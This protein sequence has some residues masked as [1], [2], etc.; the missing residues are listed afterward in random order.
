MIGRVDP[1]SPRE[2]SSDPLELRGYV[3]QLV[4]EPLLFL[5]VSY[6]DELTLHIG[7]PRQ[8]RSRRMAHLTKGSYVIG[9][10]ASLWFL[11]TQSPPTVVIGT[12]NLAASASRHLKPL[13]PEELESSDLMKPGTRILV[14]DAITVGSGTERGYAFGMSLLLEDGASLTVLPSPPLR[15]DDIAD[16]EVFTPY[17]RCLSVGPGLNWS[18]LPSHTA[19]RRES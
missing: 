13:T 1:R 5:R 7:R 9:A 12:T 6:G 18:Y 16:W 2:S 11:R 14:A 8:Y 15:S 17:E 10:R 4:G 3:Q 19:S